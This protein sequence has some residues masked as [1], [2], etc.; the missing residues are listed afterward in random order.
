LLPHLNGFLWKLNFACMTGGGHE[1][2][3]EKKANYHI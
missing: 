1:G 2:K 3:D